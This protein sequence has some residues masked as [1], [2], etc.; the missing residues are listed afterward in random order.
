MSIRSNYKQLVSA[1]KGGRL[2]IKVFELYWP[3]NSALH[4]LD[5]RIKVGGLAV[6]SLLMTMTKWQGLT[7][8]SF[9]LLGLVIL[10][11]TPLRL[12]R[13]M[14]MILVWMG[15][16]YGLSAGWVWSEGNTVWQGHWSMSGLIQAAELLWR[17][18]LIF[19]MTRLYSAV[20]RPLEQGL[21]I[22]YFFNP[23]ARIT[24]KAS[25]FALL[26][27]LTLRFI[28]LIVEEAL[29]LWKVRLLKGEWPS[30]WLKRVSEGMQLI[31]P[32]LLLSLK[33]AEELAENLTARGY[34]SGKYRPLILQDRS[35]EDYVGVLVLVI[36]GV[37]LLVL[38]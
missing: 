4:R 34:C 25:D 11:R 27:T 26:L 6:L 21:G 8:T 7:L 16:F 18:V 20:T 13:S 31:V 9:V 17:V 37:S 35:I 12:Y 3:C 14:V 28:P 10:G 32:L 38:G 2:E 29:I 23:L 15:L 1:A 30:S 33:R 24:P 22:A 19:G 5:P 36:W